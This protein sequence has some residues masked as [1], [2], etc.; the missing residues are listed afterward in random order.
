MRCPQGYAVSGTSFAIKGIGGG[1][2]SSQGLVYSKVTAQEAIILMGGKD[3]IIN[4]A[5][6]QTKFV[7]NSPNVTAVKMALEG[8]TGS[9][10]IPE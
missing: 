2:E 6:K 10:S 1:I 3:V 9:F 8:T 7:T 4:K 5:L